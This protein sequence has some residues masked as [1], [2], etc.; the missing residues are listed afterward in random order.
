MRHLARLPDWQDGA[1]CCRPQGRVIST[2]VVG[3]P[4]A[5]PLQRVHTAVLKTRLVAAWFALLP[6]LLPAAAHAGDM[7]MLP[8]GATISWDRIFITENGERQEP[9][10]P[11][12][13]RNYLNLA[14]CTCSQNGAEGTAIDYEITLTASTG[15]NRPGE[16]WIGTQCDDDTVRNMM[17]RRLDSQTIGDI[18][19]LAVTPGTIQLSLYEVVN[20]TMNT[21]A[22]QQ[23]E[24][25]AFAW[26]LVDHDGDNVYDYFSNKSVGSTDMVQGIDTQP[27]PVPTNFSA[28]GGEGSI[29]ISWD[30]PTSRETDIFAF[31]AFCARADD[32]SAGRDD[33]P[34][35]RYQTTATVCNIPQ[36]LAL[37]AVD[38]ESADAGD[39]VSAPI[40][41]FSNLEES[42]LCGDQPS[43]TATSITLGGLENG[44]AYKVALVA[45]DF[46][47]NPSGVFFTQ[48][49]TPKPVTDFWEDLQDRNS[50]VE[51]GCLNTSSGGGLVL[52]LL[53]VVPFA[54]RRRRRAAAA[55]SVLALTLVASTA[56]AD[57]F[58]PYWEDPA[59]EESALLEDADRITWHAGIRVG[60]Y[61]PDID[62]QAGL[63]AL[64]Q[65][66]PY[67]A[68]FGDWYL[69]GKKHERAVWQILPM[70]DVDRIIWD[71]FGHVGVGGS[72]GYMQ[73]T[74][75][76]Y[77]EGTSEDDPMRE[78]SRSSK[79]KFRLIPLA[80]TATYRFTYLDERFG[81]PVVPYLR[82][83][84]SYYM[85]EIEAPDGSTSKVC[86]D[87][88]DTAD[89]ETND[90]RG[91]SLGFQGSVGLSIRAERIDSAAAT[92]MRAGGIQHA[93]FYA[94]WSWAK[95]DGFGSETK[96][97][98]GD[99]TWFAGVDFEF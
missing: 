5:F 44:V 8:N 14:H 3:N 73:K 27:P 56:K 81:I 90:A 95:V 24:G 6:A 87:G 92:S 37:A 93:G 32:D 46:Y 62:I 36:E 68:M 25:D 96:L 13:L 67:E 45:V 39:P 60:P 12:A 79:T 23:R 97:A 42:F 11:D 26:V 1:V 83:G 10:T 18:D 94:E 31:Q 58:T 7:G 49:I 28:S 16:V 47:G 2:V 33:P 19:E 99:T 41:A 55:G 98:V 89:C 74:A 78:R 59:A 53:V 50:A 51:G 91:A 80:A 48:T 35:P 38:L 54:L 22:C 29:D 88:S 34:A 69:D 86:M 64:T 4:A 75:H 71:G 43:G 21:A 84:L 77:L 70:L 85:W 15:T 61:I 30:A 52:G 82:G 65:Q 9:S 66:G 20:G 57:D 40:A 63:N 76:A 17:C 72:I